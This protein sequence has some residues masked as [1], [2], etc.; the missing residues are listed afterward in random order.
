MKIK[1]ATLQAIDELAGF[2]NP[3]LEAE[4]LV[5]LTL[6]IKRS[7]VYNGDEL[8]L[9]QEQAFKRNL[10]LRKSGVPL[11]YIVHSADFYGYEF[12]VDERVLIPRPETEELVELAKNYIS[13]KSSVLDIGTGSGNIAI[14]MNLLTG[15]SVTAVDLSLGALEVAKMN[16]KNNNAKVRFVR[17]DIFENLKDE[18]FDLIIS[19]P[20]YISEEEYQNLEPSVKDYE[21]Y[22][23]LVGGKSGLEFYRRIIDGAKSHLN[24]GGH[25]FF[26]I[27]YNEAQKVI[28]LLEKA[29]F[30]EIKLKKDLEGNDRIIYCSK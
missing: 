15:A 24:D 23:A 7:E 3:T 27:G 14:V 22:M 19:N 4:W 9:G 13:A 16:A 17:S 1:D 8:S 10:D 25:I 26:E 12:Y 18:K 30:R 2:E 5:A 6:K 28:N 21:P 29:G 11:E 20:P